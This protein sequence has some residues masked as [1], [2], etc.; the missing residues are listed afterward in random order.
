MEQKTVIIPAAR[1][2][3][4]VHNQ[5]T[6]IPWGLVAPKNKVLQAITVQGRINLAGAV[7]AARFHK[8][9]KSLTVKGSNGNV[10]SALTDALPN[11]CLASHAL[12]EDNHF[13]VTPRN[14]DI[15]RNPSVAAVA[16]NY[17][18][19][20]KI[21]APL[22]GDQFTVLLELNDMI[23]TFGAGVTGATTDW[24]VIA[25]WCTPEPGMRQYMI[26]GDW[27][28][29]QTTTKKYSNVSKVA[30]F[31][32]AE[33]T[34]FVSALKAGKDLTNPQIL[35]NEDSSNDNL[36]G[37]AVDGT[38]TATRTLP[39]KDPATAADEF[40]VIERLEDPGD[41][42]IQESTGTAFSAV[43]F[44]RAGSIEEVKTEQV[45]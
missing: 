12:K 25:T 39:I 40:C 7:V 23:S 29:N 30:I 18:G 3:Y 4:N 33:F 24:T 26:L 32:A 44:T 20:Y 36:R 19:I 35:Q 37:L 1:Q 43:I 15:V 27:N 13:E 45:S 38:S 10:L 21:H 14:T 31:A 16:T 9:I 28:S 41:V 6:V 5:G 8:A 42:V 17:D 2:T 34:T 11:T 22:P